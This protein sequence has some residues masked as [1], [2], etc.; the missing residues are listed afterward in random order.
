MLGVLRAESPWRPP[1]AWRER[2]LKARRPAIRQHGAGKASSLQKPLRL[3]RMRATPRPKEHA[4]QQPR[5]HLLSVREKRVVARPTLSR[6]RASRCR[7]RRRHVGATRSCAEGPNDAPHMSRCNSAV[8]CKTNLNALSQNGRLLRAA[9]A[10]RLWDSR[11]SSSRPPFLG[12]KEDFAEPLPSAN[13]AK[14]TSWPCKRNG[15]LRLCDH[16][17]PGPAQ[18]LLAGELRLPRAEAYRAPFLPSSAAASGNFGPWLGQAGQGLKLMQ[19]P[20][21]A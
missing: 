1:R 9:G 2:R 8:T 16:D 17:L 13:Q 21:V 14:P 4:Q 10:M 5:R 6:P 20:L 18:T 12:K 15:F 19:K 3:R 11:P 7:Y